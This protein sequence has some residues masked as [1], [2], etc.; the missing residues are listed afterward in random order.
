MNRFDIFVIQTIDS[1]QCSFVVNLLNLDA[2]IQILL[3]C[4]ILEVF[5]TN[6]LKTL[7]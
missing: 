3:K 2:D 1:G 4:H 5:V 6:V 7:F